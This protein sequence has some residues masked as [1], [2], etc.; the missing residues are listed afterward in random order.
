MDLSTRSSESDCSPFTTRRHRSQLHALQTGPWHRISFRQSTSQRTRPS[1]HIVSSSIAS[2]NN[3]VLRAS[4]RRS[5]SNLVQHGVTLNSGC[6]VAPYRLD[7]VGINSRC[8]E[9]VN[10]HIDVLDLLS[11]SISHDVV[12]LFVFHS[13]SRVAGSQVSLLCDPQRQP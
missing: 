11:T 10:P 4:P 3:L 12:D 8:S 13:P 5:G 1:E 2:P 6:L 7:V 9:P